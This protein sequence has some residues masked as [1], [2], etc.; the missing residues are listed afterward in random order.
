MVTLEKLYDKAEQEN[1]NIH[2]FNLENHKGC[3]YEYKNKKFIFMN[4][5]YINSE[6]EEK[7]TLSEELAHYYTGATYNIDDTYYL[8]EKAEYKALKW[9][10][11]TLLPYSELSTQIKKGLTEIWELAEYFQ[12]S[13]DFIRQ[14]LEYYKNKNLVG[15]FYY[16]N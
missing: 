3:Y 11:N 9:Q 13:E 8:K 1:I 16:E 7:L 10:I 5:C 4:Y 12:V 2:N 6:T 14:A 15:G